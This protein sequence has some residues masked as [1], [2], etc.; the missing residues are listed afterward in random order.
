MLK[1]MVRNIDLPE[2]VILFGRGVLFEESSTT[3]AAATAT[4]RRGLPELVQECHEVGTAVIVVLL[5]GEQQQQQQEDES[6]DD[7]D[8][9]L[10]RRQL[11][12][13]SKHRTTEITIP[14]VRADNNSNTPACCS[15]VA[16]LLEAVD[17]ARVR[18]RAFGGS[19]GFG[20]QPADPSLRPPEP[21]RCVVLTAGSNKNSNNVTPHPIRAARA[22]GMRVLHLGSDDDDEGN[23]NPLF[24]AD[25]VTAD[26]GEIDFGVDDIATPGSFWL[27][28]PHP[29]DDEGNRVDDPHEWVA[30]LHAAA[31]A[32]DPHA[33]SSETTKPTA[34]V[35]DDQDDDDDDGED[36]YLDSVL[37]DLAPLK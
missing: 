8:D 18:Q 14:I 29:R 26:G 3:K 1:M 15:S 2:A 28:P 11:V 22:C 25:Y 16:F 32:A 31:A 34:R 20:A 9:E 5:P 24:L 10:L 19:S 23:E 21:A 7:D 36:D 12:P 13:A 35:M 30:E 27:N 33:P 4:I 6:D 17:R 37:A